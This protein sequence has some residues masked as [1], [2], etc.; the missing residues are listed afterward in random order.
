MAG[1]L[2]DGGCPSLPTHVQVHCNDL[3]GG[4]FMS[5]GEIRDESARQ[6]TIMPTV[7]AR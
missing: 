2:T 5:A 4:L 1:R 3:M 6:R 7:L